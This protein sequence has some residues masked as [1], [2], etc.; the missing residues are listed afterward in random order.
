MTTLQVPPF[1]GTITAGT[2]G[3]TNFIVTGDAGNAAI[4]PALLADLA[5]SLKSYGYYIDLS[6]VTNTTTTDSN[7]R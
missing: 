7:F 5:N 4:D 3:V 2:N 1:I 6:G